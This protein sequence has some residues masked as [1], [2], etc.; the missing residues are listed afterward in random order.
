MV[1][2]LE[3]DSPIFEMIKILGRLTFY[4]PEDNTTDDDNSED[5]LLLTRSHYTEFPS[6]QVKALDLDVF[7]YQNRIRTNPEE[8]YDYMNYRIASFDGLEIPDGCGD[9]CT[10]NT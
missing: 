9:G 2:D 5:S 6:A 1:Y 7:Y 3:G 8:F 4:Q 10:L